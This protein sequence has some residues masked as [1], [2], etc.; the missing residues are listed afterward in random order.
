MRARAIRCACGAARIANPIRDLRFREMAD[1]PKTPV[2]RAEEAARQ[3]E[4]EFT[5]NPTAENEAT[6]R[7][8]HNLVRS[9]KEFARK[10]PDFNRPPES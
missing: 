8:A 3:A 9:A 1:E 7:N 2:E 6:M 4:A 5:R 10:H